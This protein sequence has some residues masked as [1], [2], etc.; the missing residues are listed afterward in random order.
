[1][2]GL[3]NAAI[4]I[5]DDSPENIDILGETL[6]MYKKYIALNGEKAIKIIQEKRPD[7][8]LLDVMMPG[9]TGYEVIKIIKEDDLTKDIPVIFITAL[10][11]AED[12]KRG[13]DLGAADYITKPF[14]P[15]IVRARVKT[16]LMI[17]FQQESLLQLTKSLIEQ[18][19]IIENEQEKS[20]RLLKNIF[21]TKVIEDL[22]HH[23]KTEPQLY[24]N[25]SILF[26]DIVGF[27]KLSSQIQPADLINE[28]NEIFTKFDDIVKT[29]SCERIKTIGDCYMAVCGVPDANEKHARL[30]MSSAI[31]FVSY[32]KER[33]QNL[34]AGQHA[35]EIRVGMNSGS[36]IGGVVGTR[37]YIYDIFGDAVNV[38]SRMEN[39]SEEMRIAISERTYPLLKDFYEFDDK[40][41]VNVK[42]IGDMKIY[43]LSNKYLK[44]I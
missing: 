40:G 43:Y 11:E 19:E 20:Q 8:I 2:I 9:I 1:M 18:N 27:T 37:K 32:M 26:L 3:N 13:F 44:Y 21:P 4:L 12:E 14:K 23:G 22:K 30:L 34:K 29:Y 42:G 5:V 17:K 33:N 38:A 35:L 7:L 31:E 28:L 25:V 41:I 16:Q 15:E 10:S 39:N 36:V 24:D 6:S